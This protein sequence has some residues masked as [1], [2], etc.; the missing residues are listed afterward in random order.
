MIDAPEKLMPKAD[1][2]GKSERPD[3][4]PFATLNEAP[5]LGSG[6]S[7]PPTTAP[8]LLSTEPS[9]NYD[10]RT[11]GGF[12]A[13]DGQ[14]AGDA[15]SS[16][17]NDERVDEEDFGDFTSADHAPPLAP[18][19]METGEGGGGEGGEDFGDFTGADDAEAVKWESLETM[20]TTSMSQAQPPSTEQHKN[21]SSGDWT[22]TQADRMDS[23]NGAD[24]GERTGGG[25]DDLI[26]SNLQ[27]ATSGPQ[28]LASMVRAT[29]ASAESRPT[30]HGLMFRG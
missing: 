1:E 5:S 4:D 18:A 25:L 19:T 7:T 8:T 17:A 22:A 21:E 10:A 14:G 2:T 28:H 23:R 12:R 30:H 26:K 20:D 16:A 13:G 6:T 29:L 9:A 24:P 27:A 11:G 15:G 3:V